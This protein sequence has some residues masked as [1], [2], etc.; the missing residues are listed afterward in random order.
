MAIAQASSTQ[1]DLVASFWLLSLGYGVLRFRMTPSAGTAALIGVSAGLAALTKPHMGFLAVPW[2][3]AFMGIA[4]SR[5]RR[6]AV[7]GSWWLA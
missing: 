3:L 4:G 6:R 7:G 1:N 5:G 2:L